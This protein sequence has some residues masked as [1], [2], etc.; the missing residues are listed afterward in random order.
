M[1]YLA[2]KGYSRQTSGFLV[3]QNTSLQ[4]NRAFV[5]SNR[6]QFMTPFFEVGSQLPK[7]TWKILMNQEQP[8]NQIR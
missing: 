6:H 4:S 1:P 3:T 8:H 5:R 2:T 7:L